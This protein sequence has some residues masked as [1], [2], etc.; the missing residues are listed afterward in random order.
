MACSRLGLQRLREPLEHCHLQWRIEVANIPFECWLRLQEHAAANGGFF[1]LAAR[2]A[3]HTGNA[4]Y[5]SRAEKTWD[6]MSRIQLVHAS[7]RVWDGTQDG[8]N[9]TQV[10]L[11]AFGY[12]AGML[13][14]GSAVLANYTNGSSIWMERTEGLLGA[15]TRS[16]VRSPTRR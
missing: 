8:G 14:Y 5:L 6:R 12:T 4:T 1:Q 10:N 9:C 3:R 13:L 11:A 15:T 7:Y 2:L 16:S